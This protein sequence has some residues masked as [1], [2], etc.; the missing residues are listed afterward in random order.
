MRKIPSQLSAYTGLAIGFA[1]LLWAALRR[2]NRMN[3]WGRSV[4]I[5][6]GSRGLGLVLARCFAR[7]G[8]RVAILARDRA[9]LERARLDLAERGA[10]VL[11]LV[12]DVADQEQVRSAVHQVISAYGRLDVL[13]NNAGVIQVGPLEH[14]SLEDFEEAMAVHH[15]GPLYAMLA[16]A[17]YMRQQGGGRILNISS[18]GG[19]AAIP[20]LAP[21]VSSKF[22]LTGLSDV[23]RIELAKD[24]IRVTTVNPGLM[25]TGSHV[26]AYFKG[27]HRKEYAWFSILGANPLV[28]TSAESAARQILEACRY[29]RPSLVI[30]PQARL[31]ILANSLTPGLYS[32]AMRLFNRFLPGPA[33]SQD[34][35]GRRQGWD[36][37]SRIS[38]SFLTHLSDRAVG[39]NNEN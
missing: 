36:S 6:G 15:W 29:G 22:A 32:V 28:S 7:E 10:E 38:P 18:I 30:T 21:Y 11:A 23:F 8:A 20:H 5:S 33:A 2:K 25:R 4:L 35:D 13:V 24:N 26:N 17:P 37:Q 3:F 1:L 9:E 16:A 34:G 14:M 12:C 27:D 39:M 31:L 19:G